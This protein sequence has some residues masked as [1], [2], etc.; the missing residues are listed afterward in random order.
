L[1]LSGF[2]QAK[3]ERDKH[4]KG[5]ELAAENAEGRTTIVAAVEDYLDSKKRKNDSTVQNYTHILNEFLEQLA[6][7]I[8]FIDQVDR[9]VF[10]SHITYLENEKAAEPK[11]IHNK[12]G[13]VFQMLKSAGVPAPS[14][15]IELPTVEEEIAEPY[16]KAD[17]KKLFEQMTDE[18]MVR[19]TF[20]LDTACREKEVAHATWD[21]R[22]EHQMQASCETLCF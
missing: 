12:T 15:R 14:K 19:Y 4:E 16:T 3:M 17:L 20:F 9:K 2:E 18:E 22:L 11:T 10:S 8:K 1:I 21:D 13:V 6:P 7:S 5:I